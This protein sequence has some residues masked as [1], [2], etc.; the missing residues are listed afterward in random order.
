MRQKKFEL[1]ASLLPDDLCL[2]RLLIM[3]GSLLRRVKTHLAKK[4]DSGHLLTES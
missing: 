1:I 2:H 3:N 4:I